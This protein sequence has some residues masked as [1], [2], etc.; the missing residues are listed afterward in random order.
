MKRQKKESAEFDRVFRDKEMPEDIPEISMS[1]LEIK[2]GKIWVIKLLLTAGMVS[3]KNEAIRLFEQ[4]GV[5]VN[6]NKITGADIEAVENT[7]I[8][9][10]KRRYI[11][12][13]K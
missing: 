5:T 13:V 8:K 2:D 11:K 4:G 1:K 7:I 10:G 12:L 3:S 6:G 9:A